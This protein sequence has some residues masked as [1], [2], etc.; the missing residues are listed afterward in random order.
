MSATYALIRFKKTGNIYMGCYEG[1]SDIM[2][3]YI[4]T[5]EEC[6]D[7]KWDCYCAISYCRELARGKSYTFPKDAPDV[8][9]CEV[10]ADYGGG[11]YWDGIGSESLKMIKSPEFEWGELD[12]EETTDGTPDWVREY[13]KELGAKDD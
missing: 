10:Y 4:C 6:W 5:P 3:P 7:E 11:F 2:V 1:T 8:D 9:E 13:W 12:Y